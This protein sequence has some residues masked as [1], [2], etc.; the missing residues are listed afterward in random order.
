MKHTKIISCYFLS[1]L[2]SLSLFIFAGCSTIGEMPRVTKLLVSYQTMGATL[3]DAKP[4]ILALCASGTL[5]EV[6]CAKAKKAYNQAVTVY[7]TLGDAV[8]SAVITGDDTRVRTLTLQL[9]NLLIIVS[10][11]LVTQ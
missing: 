8:D 9:Q 1:L 4:T 5:E 7:K 11:F 10:Q 2:L 3:E 6:D